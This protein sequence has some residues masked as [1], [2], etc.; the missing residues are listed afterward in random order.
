MLSRSKDKIIKAVASE[1]VQKIISAKIFFAKL[2]T[3]EWKRVGDVMEGVTAHTIEI[4][5]PPEFA[6]YLYDKKK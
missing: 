3:M 5:V 2:K 4:A 1:K 6:K